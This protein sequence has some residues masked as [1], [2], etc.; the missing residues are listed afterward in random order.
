MLRI[1]QHCQMSEDMAARWKVT[2]GF[3]KAE[4]G[5]GGKAVHNIQKG[6]GKDWWGEQGGGEGVYKGTEASR[7]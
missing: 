2:G 3:G 4:S 5:K 7:I 6:K 1:D